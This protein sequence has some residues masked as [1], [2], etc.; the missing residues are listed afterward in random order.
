MITRKGRVRVGL[1]RLYL[2]LLYEKNFKKLDKIVSKKGKRVRAKKEG[3]ILFAFALKVLRNLSYR[4]LAHYLK[5]SNIFKDI[6]DF[7][8][9]HYKSKKLNLNLLI[10]F[11]KKFADIN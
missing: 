3:L 9:F 5:S 4:D 10:Y 7:S 2:K 11:I 8:S 6:L 1:K